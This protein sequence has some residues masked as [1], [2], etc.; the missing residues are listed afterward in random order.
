MKKY[1]YCHIYILY[2]VFDFNSSQTLSYIES[3]E[4]LV[5]VLVSSLEKTYSSDFSLFNSY[6]FSSS[7]SFS[8]VS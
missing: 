7:S 3:L 2:V 4:L 6:F 1:I 8:L 5:V